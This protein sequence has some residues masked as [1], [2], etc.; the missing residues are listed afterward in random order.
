MNIHSRISL[1]VK[2]FFELGPSQLGLYAFYRLCLKTGV[3]RWVEGVQNRKRNLNN[4]ALQSY[5]VFLDLPE[6]GDI[7]EII[8]DVGILKL[9]SEADEIV[10]GNVRLFGGEPVPLVLIPAGELQHWSGYASDQTS[11]KHNGGWQDIKFVWEPAR[12]GW[13][14]KLGRAYHILGDETYAETFWNYF[15]LF[16]K[17][18]PVN[19]GPNWLSAQEV[20][21]RILAFSFAL[22]TFDSSYHTTEKRKKCLVSSIAEHAERIPLTLIYARA[23]NNNHLLSEALGLITASY[24]LHEHPKAK[25]WRDLGWKWFNRG[26]IKQIKQ[27]GSYIQ[28]S[29]NYHRF[30]LQLILWSSMFLHFRQNQWTLG[31]DESVERKSKKAV[32]WLLAMCDPETGQVPNLGSN[33]GSY[34]IPLT[35]LPWKDYRPVLQAGSLILLDYPA[36]KPGVWDEMAYWFGSKKIERPPSVNSDSKEGKRD[37]LI[38]KHPVILNRDDTRGYFRAVRFDSRPGHADQLHLDLWWRGLNVAQD[39]GTYLYNGQPPWDNPFTHSEVHNTVI[40]DRREQMMRVSRFLYLDRAQAQVIEEKHAD[41]SSW[42][43]IEASHNGYRQLGVIHRRGVTAYKQGI[44][45]VEDKI[46]NVDEKVEGLLHEVRLHWLLPD[47]EWKIETIDEGKLVIYL[48]SPFGWI[49]L[50][51]SSGEHGFHPNV[52]RRLPRVNPKLSFYMI[53][54]ARCGELLYGTGEVSPITGWTSPTYGQKKPA[55]SAAIVV[56]GELPIFLVTEWKF[57]VGI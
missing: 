51:I 39:P 1:I 36:F 20:A 57:P 29:T 15:E 27:D 55:L 26:L 23:Q 3:F 7:R 5:R 42:V 21:L 46:H 34:I 16:Q 44:W 2:A 19:M 12:F 33:D 45:V 25:R 30:V 48:L 40:I 49:D 6:P 32:Q 52:N 35:D 50:F 11:A 17:T 22:H 28:H 4:H 53:Q 54:L 14:F 31:L 8:G 38:Q 13:A 24:L 37:D 18:N 10:A 56:K 43:R 41:D 9:K 47:W